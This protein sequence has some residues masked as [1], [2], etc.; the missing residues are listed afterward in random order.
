MKKFTR[1]SI[2]GV[3]ITK[4]EKISDHRGSILPM[5][6]SDSKSFEKFGEIYFS[7]I[8]YNSIKA[9]HLHKRAVLNY[10]C[11]K[12]KVRLV[13]FDDRKNSNSFGKY[14]EY[15]LTP[16]DY[17]LVKIPQLVWNGF[18][19]LDKSESIVANC[20]SIPHDEKEMLRKNYD[21]EYFNYHWIK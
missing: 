19:G 2:E 12:G 13:I 16:N 17:F 6:R 14:E 4:I 15:I 8:F 1:G 21:D 18:I 5:L 11:I 7:T 3:N 20:I 10:V 9:W